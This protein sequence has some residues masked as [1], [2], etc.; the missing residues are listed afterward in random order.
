MMSSIPSQTCGSDRLELS[1]SVSSGIHKGKL[2]LKLEMS[3]GGVQIVC[4]GQ[5]RVSNWLSNL[6][7]YNIRDVL[8]KLI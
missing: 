4:H 5:Q 3:E 8:G 7:N 6:E 1:Q 2:G